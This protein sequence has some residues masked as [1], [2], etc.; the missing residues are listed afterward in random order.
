VYEVGSG[1][2]TLHK[3]GIIHRDIKPANILISKEGTYKVGLKL[4][5]V[6]FNLFI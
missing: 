2:N 6:Y 5:F 1:V 3:K 4:M